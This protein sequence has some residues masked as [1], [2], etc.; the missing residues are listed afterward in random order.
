V[1]KPLQEI[2]KASLDLSEGKLDIEVDYK[3]KNELGVVADSFRKFTGNLKFI[4]ND[5]IG[6]LNGMSD[7][8]FTVKSQNADA[9]I[10]SYEPIKVALRKI[11]NDLSS[12]LLSV[13]QSA[14]QVNA[15]SDQVSGGAQALSQGATEQASSI[16]EL[17]ATIN[18]ITNKI[19]ENAENA[20][21]AGKESEEAGQGVT[22]SNAYMKQMIE[23]ME[24]ITEKSNEI[25]NI[26][27]TIDD[28]AFQTN[29]L[30]LNAAVEAARAGAAGKGF[31]VVADEVRN[32]AAKSA[33]AAKGTTAL[34]EGAIEAV[35]NGTKI[36]NN[37]ANALGVVV[38][39]AGGVNKLIQQIAKAS[40]EQA[41]GV[42]QV[43]IGVDQ[44]SAVVQTNSATAEQ[45]AA[46][47]EELSSQATMLKE[48]LNQFTF[49]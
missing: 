23:A 28:I 20:K 6:L 41:N 1:T 16:E 36:A 8:D 11:L 13:N 42:A 10:N 17:S 39:K 26:I 34:I 29:I 35:Q 40:E 7:S 45:S 2:E 5:I 12:T 4:I 44:I 18:D 49:R 43:S 22:D 9:Y 3:S 31:A 47:S 33:E 37:T 14:A 48:M 24:D 46:A 27:K 19:R 32:L 25:G 38:E 15:G 21:I 30:A